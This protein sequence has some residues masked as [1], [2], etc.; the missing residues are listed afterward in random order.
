MN[1]FC[2][3]L[4][5]HEF[6]NFLKNEK[7]SKYFVTNIYKKREPNEQAK[8]TKNVPIIGP[9]KKPKKTTTGKYNPKKKT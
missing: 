7:L 6:S 4:F 3:N 8:L 5:N 1:S 2:L 9:K